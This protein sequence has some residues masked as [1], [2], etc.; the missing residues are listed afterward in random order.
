MAILELQD[1]NYLHF[2]Q[3]YNSLDEPKT[4]HVAVLVLNNISSRFPDFFFSLSQFKVPH[5]GPT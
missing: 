5:C 2:C 1:F 3:V 4:D